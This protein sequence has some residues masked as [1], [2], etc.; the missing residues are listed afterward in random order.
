M[1]KN[2]PNSDVATPYMSRLTATK[3]FQNRAQHTVLP[4]EFRNFNTT[5]GTKNFL[6]ADP[7]RQ[8]PRGTEFEHPSWDTGSG[9]TE[10]SH[11]FKRESTQ[12]QL[13]STQSFGHETVR[14]IL[15]LLA[16]TSKNC[17]SGS[18]NMQFL[19]GWVIF[20]RALMWGRMIWNRNQTP[21]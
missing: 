14:A 21:S 1:R 2:R 13:V 18:K 4:Q 10:Q 5:F 11:Q 9:D 3:T 16:D 20:E 15:T 8:S 17:T 19:T 6:G 12:G 7:H